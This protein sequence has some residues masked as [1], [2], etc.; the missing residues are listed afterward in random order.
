[1]I[2]TVYSLARRVHYLGKL[3]PSLLTTTQAKSV[4]H[5]LL[6]FILLTKPLVYEKQG[7]T[8]GH[9]LFWHQAMECSDEC[10]SFGEGGVYKGV[11]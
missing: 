2:Q 4:W 11:E 10:L 6:D 3:E 8:K 5:I 7:M 9:V 1:M